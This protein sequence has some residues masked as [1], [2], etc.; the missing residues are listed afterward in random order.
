VFVLEELDSRC[1][2]FEFFAA[3][4]ACLTADMV[5]RV[6]LGQYPTFHLVI[7]GTPSLDMLIAFLPLG[8]VSA[9][10][11]CLFNRTLLTAQK[12]I[13]L[14][15]WPRFFGWFVL[16]AMVTSVGWLTPDLLGGGQDFVNGILEGRVFTLQT[17]VLFFIIR[18]IVTIGSSSSGAAGGIFMPVLVLGALL[19]LGVGSATHLLFPELNVDVKLFAVVGM[20][21]YFTGVVLAPLTGIVLIIEMTGNYAL[22]LPLFVACFS[23][24]IVADWLG[25]VPIYD[26]LLEN[27][28]RRNSTEISSL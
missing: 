18:F 11:G 20:A 19:G 6:V 7:A 5:C 25:V 16:V 12:L 9:L 3:A 14:P 23:A 8:I 1:S 27:D 4:I 2:S 28:L 21:S 24:Q 13:S 22:I 15:L 26:A 10:L 17:I